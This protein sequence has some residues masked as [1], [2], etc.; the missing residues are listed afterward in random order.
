MRDWR[1]YARRLGPDLH[2][3]GSS[4]LCGTRRPQEE[5]EPISRPTRAESPTRRRAHA[6]GRVSARLPGLLGGGLE[7][8]PNDPLGQLPPGTD[9]PAGAGRS[10]SRG[11]GE[12]QTLLETALKRL[13]EGP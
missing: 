7:G 11:S 13:Q 8:A 2:P 12:I 4:R 6:C 3:R 1:R 9:P 5:P 10:A